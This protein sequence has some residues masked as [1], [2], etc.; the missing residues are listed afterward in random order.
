M[1]ENEA[2]G[3]DNPLSPASEKI[4]TKCQA[5]FWTTITK[6]RQLKYIARRQGKTEHEVMNKLLDIYLGEEKP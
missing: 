2:S 5:R 1:S 6:W 4:V 3:K